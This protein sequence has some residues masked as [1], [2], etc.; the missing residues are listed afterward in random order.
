MGLWWVSWC[1]YVW[2]AKICLLDLLPKLANLL[3]PFLSI[4]CSYNLSDSVPF[5]FLQ[6]RTL[7]SPLGVYKQGRLHSWLEIEGVLFRLIPLAG[8]GL[9]RFISLAKSGIS[10]FQTDEQSSCLL[11]RN[12]VDEAGG[13]QGIGQSIRPSSK[14]AYGTFFNQRTFEELIP[15]RL[16]P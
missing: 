6:Q 7:I 16:D 4:F 2:V 9:S 15:R 3:Y 8:M 5:F 10:S 11:A 13:I 1:S 12:V 14:L